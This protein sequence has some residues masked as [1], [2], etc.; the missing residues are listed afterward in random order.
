MHYLGPT[1]VD[2]DEVRA[3]NRAFLLLLATDANADQYLRG[4]ADRQRATLLG[5]SP[6]QRDRLADAPFLLFSLGVRDSR[7]WSELTGGGA[8]R[9]LFNEGSATEPPA[10]LV[11]AALGFLWQLARQNPYALR[12]VSGA[13]PD[14]CERLAEMPLIAIIERGC[15]RDDVL[16]LR[17]SSDTSVWDKLLTDGVARRDTLRRAAQL[18]ALHRMLTGQTV[19]PSRRWSAAACRSAPP[20]LSVAEQP[21]N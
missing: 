1:A 21:G 5:L 3:L 2:L 8:E 20:L 19:K 16:R 12:L 6:A 13:A 9:G 15:A 11:S 17:E 4:L 10:R 7:L 14:W 18:S